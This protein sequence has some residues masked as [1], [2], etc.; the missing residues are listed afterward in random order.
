MNRFFKSFTVFLVIIFSISSVSA[1]T[2][3][4]R[5]KDGSIDIVIGTHT[6][7]SNKILFK[8]LSLIQKIE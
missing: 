2:L 6:L 4:D 5:L 8:N 3:T 7:L 1:A